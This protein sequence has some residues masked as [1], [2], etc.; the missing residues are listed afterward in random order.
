MTENLPFKLV[1]SK[2]WCQFLE[3]CN[4]AVNE[5]LAR[6]DTTIQGWVMQR[7]QNEKERI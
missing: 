7:F 5:Q 6:F 4:P 2:P 1:R 3:F